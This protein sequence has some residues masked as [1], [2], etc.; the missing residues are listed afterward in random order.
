MKFFSMKSPSGC[1][2]GVEAQEWPAQHKKRGCR[3]RPSK[4]RSREKW[5]AKIGVEFIS[6]SHHKRE[7]VDQMSTGPAIEAAVEP[8]GSSKE[9][10]WSCNFHGECAPSLE[11]PMKG[12][13]GAAAFQGGVRAHLWCMAAGI[14]AVLLFVPS[15]AHEVVAC[16]IVACGVATWATQGEEKKRKGLQMAAAVAKVKKLTKKQAEKVKLKWARVFDIMVESGAAGPAAM[17]RRLWE[18]AEQGRLI[19]KELRLQEG[20]AAHQNLLKVKSELGGKQQ[21]LQNQVREMQVQFDY[22]NGILKK[23]KTEHGIEI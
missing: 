2:S 5:L 16:G 15:W 12:E 21:R 9:E 10:G 23:L 22:V 11:A 17:F 8:V 20:Q 6:N 19:E 18:K 7:V 4:R 3:G 14:A 1:V 13:N